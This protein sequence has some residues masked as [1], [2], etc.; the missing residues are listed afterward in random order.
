MHTNQ[1][2]FASIILIIALVVIIV[3]VGVLSGIGSVKMVPPSPPA[4][5]TEQ[6]QS[7]TT[8]SEFAVKVK[9]G[10]EQNEKTYSAHPS[11]KAYLQ[12]P[13]EIVE[14]TV[15]KGSVVIPQNTIGIA[16]APDV[17]WGDGSADPEWGGSPWQYDSAGNAIITHTYTKPGSY[18]ITV[19]IN[20]GAGV[21][22]EQGTAVI[23]KDVTVHSSVEPSPISL[24]NRCIQKA[25]GTGS[26]MAQ[27]RVVE[28]NQSTKKCEWVN[29]GGCNFSSPFNNTTYQD[30]DKEL[31]LCQ[32]VCEI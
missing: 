3:G 20:G 1:K 13:S 6:A 24:D 18:I 31:Q 23:K 15:W 32:K 21:G 28:F 4:T 25:V 7:Q 12:G 22:F 2:G 17:M 10:G 9:Q 26:C 14:N 19:Y 30:S 27:F 8:S 16:N 29:V 11:I 5:T